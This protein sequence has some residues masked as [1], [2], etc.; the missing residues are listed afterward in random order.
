MASSDATSGPP[1]APD[2]PDAP[3]PPGAPGAGTGG[4]PAA[5][6]TPEE[7]PTI[8]E[9][10]LARAGDDHP[11]L[12]HDGESWTYAQYVEA[13]SQRA[14]WL[15]ANRPPDVPFHVGLLLENIPEFP[16][17][18]GA[19]ALSGAAA[20]GI[21]P[22]R[23]GDQL[24]RDVRHTDCA[25]VVTEPA[26]MP[27]LDGL[28][29][30]VPPERVLV[31]GTPGYLEAL[32]PHR[33]AAPPAVD[34]AP[35]DLFALIFTSGTSGAPKAV[36][37]SHGRLG[38]IASIAGSM[39][40]LGPGSV[41]YEAMPLFH[42]NALMA[43]WAPSL[44]T[45][46]AVA[47]RRRFSASAFI[48]DVRRY[49][50]T[51]F[52]YVGKPLAYILATPERPDDADNPLL[53][54]FGNEAAEADVEGFA[55][56][57]DCFVVDA[58]GSTE[59][60]AIVQRTPDTPPGSLGRPPEGTVVIDPTTGEECPPA[61]FDAD[62]RLLNADE[63]VG[64]LVNRLG[65]AGFE[66]YWNND[67]ASTARVRDGAYW[68][69]DLAYR[70]ASGF[71][72]F[73]GRDADW[74][75]VD[76]ENFAAAPVERILGRHPDV[77]LVS[78]YGV[79]DVDAGDQVMAALQLRPEAEFDPEAFRAFLATQADLG[80]K[81]APRYVRI[82]AEMPVTT[83]SKVLKRTLRRERWETDD[84]VWWRAD[85]RDAAYR[86]F[87]ASDAAGLRRRFEERGRT[88]VLDAL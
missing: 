63:A 37:C 45:G 85:P 59:G 82:T 44:A 83:T 2:A 56:R 71:V 58:Y 21:N 68:T 73:A 10:I 23:R 66:G 30:D 18:L 20:V 35:G 27:L 62:G 22:T 70:D 4:G 8:A 42:S 32:A 13:C 39:M 74:L 52:N 24:A 41:T 76:G 51:Y 77:M 26:L 72:Y 87:G 49:G 54:A 47:L 81:A 14:A 55:S 38:N 50:A 78:V 1:D 12:L 40:G 65:G 34:V 46:A 5:A 67:E 3:D 60:A 88:A 64:E 31:V 29:L 7:P 36:L 69:G 9:L 48:D 61:R 57:F 79:P 53:L 75:R 25:F 15:L 17:W 6:A 19:T 80:T 84:E 33:G 86:R 43:G 28:D 16:M 11:A